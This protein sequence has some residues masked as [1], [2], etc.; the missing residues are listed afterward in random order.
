MYVGM[1]DAM[2][3]VSHSPIV[4]GVLL[5]A[6]GSSR[7]GTP[8]QLLEVGGESLVARAAR[9]L[10]AAC[11]AGV[12]VVTGAEH[13]RIGAAL[14]GV[15]V[16]LCHNRDWRAGMGSSLR[17]GVSESD[18]EADGILVALCDQPFVGPAEFATLIAAFR[19]APDR[20]AAAGYDETVGVPAVFPK[21]ARSALASLRGDRGGAGTHRLRD[22]S[23]GRRDARSRIRRRH[24]GRC[25]PA[26]GGFGWLKPLPAGA[27]ARVAGC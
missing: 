19:A 5:A 1:L 9:A 26:D 24:A 17:Y 16:R 12:V 6:G 2:N 4:A 15:P 3:G 21:S 13:E 23:D 10:L 22:Q 14:N 7:L 27:G 18:T 8:K 20:I 11:S 25:R